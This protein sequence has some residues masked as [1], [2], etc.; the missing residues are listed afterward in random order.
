[1]ALHHGDEHY[2]KWMHIENG[3]MMVRRLHRIEI[4]ARDGRLHVIRGEDLPDG[5]VTS[6]GHGHKCKHIAQILL[7][8]QSAGATLLPT[9]LVP[10]CYD[11]NDTE[12]A[13]RFDPY[14]F[15]ASVVL[16]AWP[17]RFRTMPIRE[18]VEKTLHLEAPAHISLKTVLSA[19]VVRR[20]Q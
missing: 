16:P 4:Q 3:N 11:G 9:A 5:F 7:R 15:R 2:T 13:Q 1:M 6:A 10:E 12:A 17:R 18:H 14:S 8:P 19:L 20:L